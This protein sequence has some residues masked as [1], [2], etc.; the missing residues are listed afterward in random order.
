MAD[1]LIMALGFL[2][3]LKLNPAG[4]GHLHRTP[5]RVGY[6]VHFTNTGR[7]LEQAMRWV[8]A[9]FLAHENNRETLLLADAAFHWYLTSQSYH[10]A[11]EIFSF[12]YSVLDNVHSLTKRLYHT[13][14]PIGGHAQRA[15]SL[16]HFYDIPL[17][18]GI[19]R[20]RQPYAQC[21][22]ARRRAQRPC[23]RGA[24]ARATARLRSGFRVVGPVAKCE[25][26]Q[27]PTT[28]WRVGHR[29]QIQVDSLRSP[30]PRS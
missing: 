20:L 27:Q 24:M 6:L 13:Y 17:Q 2:L 12:Q 25:A 16:A 14:Q 9:F 7:D 30:D 19:S 23:A 3:G 11:F 26:F 28:A 5:R 8:I 1:F 10:H 18:T 15:V 29:V 4:M 22:T 21:E